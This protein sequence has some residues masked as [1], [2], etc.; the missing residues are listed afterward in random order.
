[1]VISCP[2]LAFCW[3]TYVTNLGIGLALCSLIRRDQGSQF[4]TNGI[5]RIPFFFLKLRLNLMGLGNP[6]RCVVCVI[7]WSHHLFCYEKNEK[8]MNEIASLL[9]LNWI[10]W[11]TAPPTHF[12]VGPNPREWV[13][14][15]YCL[16]KWRF[17]WLYFPL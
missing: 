8:T 7:V 4:H 15:S 17:D 1:M 14:S 9:I 16:L 6:W 5:V 11:E 2:T 12:D 13:E 3:L 10:M